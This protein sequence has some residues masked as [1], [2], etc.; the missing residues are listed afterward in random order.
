MTIKLTYQE[1]EK[2][3]EILRQKLGTKK[4]EEKF[5]SFFENNKAAMLQVDTVTK[6]IINANDAAL[7]FYGY[8]KDKLF[9]LTINDLNNLPPDE[10]NKLMKK[11]IKNKSNFFQFQHRLANNE[12]KDVEIYSSPFKVGDELH[13]FV[14]VHDITDRKEAEKEIKKQNVEYVSLNEELIIAIKK[15]EESEAKF[16]N[17]SDLT[18]EGIIIHSKGIA[19]DTN[20]SFAKIFG[21]E[22]EELLGKN[23]IKLLFPEKY[24]RE[25]AENITKNDTLSYETEGIKKDGSIFPVEIE[26]RFINEKDKNNTLRVAAVRDITVRKEVENELLMKNQELITS[27]E[28]LQATNEELIATTEA[29]EEN[30]DELT[31]AKGKV[32]KSEKKFRGLFEKS[33]DAILIIKNGIFVDCNQATIDMLGYKT[34]EEILNTHP[35]K[36]SPEIQADGMESL[37]KAEDMMRIAIKNG[38]HRF[39]WWHTKSDGESFPVEVLLTAITN[40]PEK[41]VIHT[42]WRDISVRKKAEKEV[43]KLLIAIEQSANIIMI[44]DTAGRIEYTNPKFSEITSYTGQEVL[45]INP[46]ILSAGTQAEKHYTNLWQTIAAG[47]TWKGEFHNKTKSGELFWEQATI[48]PIKNEANKITNYLAI[49]EDITARK[50]SEQELLQKNQELQASEEEIRAANEELS[51]TTKALKDSNKEL[52]IAKNKA[53]ESDQLKTEFINNMSHEIRTPMNGILGFSSFLD[54]PDLTNKEQKQYINII[55]SSGNQL[56]RI[57]DDILEISELGTKQVKVT[58]KEVCLNNLLSEQFLIFDVKAKESK[59]QLHLKKGLPDKQSTILGDQTKLNK[60]VSNLLENALKFTANGFIEFGYQIVATDRDFVGTGRDLSLR[61]YVKDT[62][63]GIKPESQKTIFDRF[64][65]EEKGL[66]RNVGGLGLGLSIAKEN[67]ELLGGK[68]TLKSEKG[69]GATFFVTIPYKPIDPVIETLNQSTTDNATHSPKSP[70]KEYTILIV[71]DE[72]LNYLYIKMLLKRLKP[73]L[74]TLHVKN[75]QEAVDLC[76]NKPEIDFVLMDLKMPVMNGYEAT[77][78]IKKIRPD[79]PIVAQ[80]AYSTPTDK[81]KAIAAG[82][83][84]F[85]SKPISQKALNK[86]INRYLII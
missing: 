75:G 31:K 30:N 9:R 61:I 24:H 67:T 8:S 76:K 2:E 22:S 13:M 83:N 73:I 18:F 28:E 14:T 36:L 15:A 29:L 12:I 52:I 82:C 34:K 53:E 65:Q 50:K 51:S 35:S 39:E 55:Q 45:G 60:I 5:N 59:I 80:T 7:N 69:K 19:I 21:Y 46:K 66:S 72:K 1:L 25:I 26:A 81:E 37:E 16:K 38:T 78:L 56:L 6:Q 64:S 74:N 77:K 62:G 3:N 63:I 11:A 20:R 57:I 32:E 4:C 58:N 70:V 85:V 49:K 17:L 27:E 43:K 86:I 33:G 23:V 71:E 79:L 44:T 68:I 40:K 47:K 48:T 41:K 42:V 10:T 84:D 54:S